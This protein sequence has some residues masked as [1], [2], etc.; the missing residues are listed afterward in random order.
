MNYLGELLAK[1][2]DRI[3]QIM[4]KIKLGLYIII[5]AWL[6]SGCSNTSVLTPSSE[7]S[8]PQTDIEAADGS[9]DP[10]T[11]IA[12]D[13]E[14]DSLQLE[15]M[16]SFPVQVT[17]VINGYLPDNC[18]A[19]EKINADYSKSI[20]KLTITTESKG[21]DC[22]Q[23]PQ[24]FEERIALGIEG[25]HAGRYEVHLGERTAVFKLDQDNEEQD[26]GCR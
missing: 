12:E 6:L 11:E 24:P 17:A 18:T 4:Y 19:I 22:I 2:A 26:P 5:M 25:L 3:S 8:L 14:I 7:D 21:T 9:Q 10:E 16:E 13:V 20:F 23:E 1:E 15:I